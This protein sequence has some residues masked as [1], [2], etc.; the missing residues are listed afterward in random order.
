MSSPISAWA[1]HLPDPVISGDQDHEW[2][3]DCLDVKPQ[4]EDLDVKARLG[5][6]YEIAPYNP[7]VALKAQTHGIVEV[8]LNR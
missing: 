2:Q 5:E 3:W 7:E 8:A 4:K 6:N 1:V